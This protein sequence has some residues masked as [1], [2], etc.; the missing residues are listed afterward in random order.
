[1]KKLPLICAIG[2]AE[3]AIFACLMGRPLLAQEKTAQQIID[4][5]FDVF[6]KNTPPRGVVLAPVPYLI[7]DGSICPF[8]TAMDPDGTIVNSPVPL[9]LQP[10]EW[11]AMAQD[12]K[13]VPIPQPRPEAAPK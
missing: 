6:T 8:M 4:E 10:K 7:C 1:M 11:S 2:I 9:N 3:L 12:P 13:A 5:D